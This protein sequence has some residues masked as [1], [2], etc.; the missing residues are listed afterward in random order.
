[1][2]KKIQTIGTLGTQN[3]YAYLDEV[4]RENGRLTRRV[5]LKH[6]Q[7]SAII[8]FVSDN[9]ILMVKQYRYA[10]KRE[11]LEIPAGKIDNGEDPEQ[12]IKRELIE[13]T[14]FN[15]RHVKWLYTYAPA[16]GYS[17]EFIHIF[18]GRDLCEAEKG[19]NKDEISS[20]EILPVEKALEM[21]KNHEILDG[22]TI[23]AM[24]LT[25]PLI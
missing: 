24:A 23:I 17:N 21:I 4:R 19:Y 16:V 13:E 10:L 2:E 14:G 3:F 7:A 18:E 8:P 12:C 1:M 15:A 22:K 20:V 6:P 25:M 9:E 11:M 5:C